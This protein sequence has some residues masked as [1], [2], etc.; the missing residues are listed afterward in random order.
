MYNGWPFTAQTRDSDTPVLPP[1][2]STTEPPR[3][4]RPSA[5][6]ASIMASAMRSFMLPVGFSLSSLS[7]MRAPF[8]GTT[9]RRGN[10][11]GVA[12]ALQDVPPYGLHGGC[13]L[14]RM[15]K[16]G[17]FEPRLANRGRRAGCIAFS[18]AVIRLASAA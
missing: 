15:R 5:S 8:P 17:F 9:W 3:G 6:A 16:L 4:R 13:P 2:Y 7:R 12:D 11:R 10:K 18:I 14:S 1:V